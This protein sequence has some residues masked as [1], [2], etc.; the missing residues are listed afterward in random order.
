MK[1][2]REALRQCLSLEQAH[3]KL[4]TNECKE[5]KTKNKSELSIKAFMV[6]AQFHPP[7]IPQ[8]QK[9]FS[10]KRFSTGKDCPTEIMVFL[11]IKR[12]LEVGLGGDGFPGRVGAGTPGIYL[13]AGRRGG[14]FVGPRGGFPDRKSPSPRLPE[15]SIISPHSKKFWWKRFYYKTFYL[16]F[17]VVSPSVRRKNWLW[18]GSNSYFTSNQVRQSG[19]LIQPIQVR[20]SKSGIDPILFTIKWKTKID[21]F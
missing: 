18:P 17:I 5:T 1:R 13:G 11:H 6:T 14:E 7:K 4:S 3:L 20:Y 15:I 8:I 12:H 10:Q 16:T 9:R 2:G 19:C 21:I